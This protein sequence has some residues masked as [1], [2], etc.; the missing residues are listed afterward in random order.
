MAVSVAMLGGCTT[1]TPSPEPGTALA[2]VS[3]GSLRDAGS[4]AATFAWAPGATVVFPDDRYDAGR[5]RG[6]IQSEIRAVL[7][8]RGY[9]IVDAASADRRVAFVLGFDNNLTD[10]RLV[11]LFGLDPGLQT[12]PDETKGTLVIA[13]TGPSQSRVF[14]RGAVQA[15]ATLDTDRE[16]RADRLRGAVRRLLNALPKR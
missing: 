15:V 10:D 4:G 13:I 8:E 5:A 3:T 2:T 6:I 12:T 16:A 11:S 1:S 9:Q 14:W 7:S